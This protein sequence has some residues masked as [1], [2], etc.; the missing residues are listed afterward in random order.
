[1][2]A[3]IALAVR[4][5]DRHIDGHAIA[6]D[7]LLGKLAGDLRPVFG[8]DFGW[9]GQPPFAGSDRV[10]TGLAGLRTPPDHAVTN[11]RA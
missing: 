1:M 7:Q 2:I 3:L 10:T 8:A 6:A 5:M 9:Q 11:F 4:C